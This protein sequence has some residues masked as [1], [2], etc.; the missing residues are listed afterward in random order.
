VAGTAADCLSR[1]ASCRRR[2]RNLLRGPGA[3]PRRGWGTG[4]G[5]R[6]ALPRRGAGQRPALKAFG[7]LKNR[8][9]LSPLVSPFGVGYTAFQGSVL[10]SGKTP[11]RYAGICSWHFV[12]GIL[13][14]AWCEI[15]AHPKSTP[16][17]NRPPG[18][19]RPIFWL[20]RIGG[21]IL[22]LGCS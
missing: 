19:G 9:A 16:R 13:F 14:V 3:K 2:C 18:N 5:S 11:S 8:S 20:W 22:R 1:E 10:T 4:K 6:R 7:Q 21:V 17:L 15:G 12:R